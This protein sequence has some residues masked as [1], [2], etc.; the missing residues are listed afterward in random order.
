MEST[1]EKLRLHRYW[2]FCYIPGGIHVTHAARKPGGDTRNSDH[3]WNRYSRIPDV[4]F[5]FDDRALVK[6]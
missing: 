4:T 5:D 3:S 2:F 1:K 6:A